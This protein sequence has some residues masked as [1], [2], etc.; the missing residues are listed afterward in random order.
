MD[1]HQYQVETLALLGYAIGAGFY[2]IMNA[3]N[4]SLIMQAQA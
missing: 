3:F 4:G 1:A 2:T